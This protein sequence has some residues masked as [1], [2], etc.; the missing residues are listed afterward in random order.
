M[1]DVYLLQPDPHFRSL[2][3]PEDEEFF[4]LVDRFDGRAISGAW[5]PFEVEYDEESIHLPN[6]DFPSM[7]L[8]HIPLFA[9]RA[10]EALHPLLS[11]NGELLPLTL[12]QENYFAF[13]VH[14]LVDALNREK[15]D[16]VYYPSGRVLDVNSY[17]LRGER[18]GSEA[19]FKL[20]DTALMDVFVTDKFLRVVEHQ[21]LLGFSFKPVVVA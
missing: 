16:L 1:N 15:S 7:S 17:V 3:A 21:Y 12:D 19:I 11:S 6:G 10:T 20:P 4:E 13:N 5:R 8:P 18:M 9:A 14:T 2:V